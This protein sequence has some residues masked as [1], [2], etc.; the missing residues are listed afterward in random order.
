MRPLGNKGPLIREGLADHFK[1]NLTPAESE[2]ERRD[3][4]EQDAIRADIESCLEEII[5]GDELGDDFDLEM[6][7]DYDPREDE[8]D[9]YYIE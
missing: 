9:E 2:M 6:D 4:A 3:K 1:L 8:Y 5:L 7:R